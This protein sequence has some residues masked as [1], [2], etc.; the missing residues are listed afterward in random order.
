MKEL[1]CIGIVRRELC[2]PNAYAAYL[3]YVANL[4]QG[5]VL[6]CTYVAVVLKVGGG[7]ML[8]WP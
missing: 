2:L 5:T 4:M 3:Q 1:V 8:S 6:V 7:G